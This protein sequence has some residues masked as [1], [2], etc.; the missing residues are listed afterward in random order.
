MS[1]II[2]R[3]YQEKDIRDCVK[4]IQ[5]FLTE[6]RGEESYTNH[7]KNFHFDVKKTE[8]MLK[9]GLY[10][11]KFFCHLIIKDEEIVGGLCANIGELSCFSD[12]VA[13]DELL[14]IVPEFKNLKALFKL[15]EE[16]CFWAQECGAIEARLCSSTGFN[17]EGFTKLCNK[18]NFHQFEI[19]FAR[20]F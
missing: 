20:R 10:N 16:Y 1:K 15:I 9:R 12:A 11:S 6:D 18:L 7:Y 2:L 13:Y 4:K 3:R 5:Q 19:G 17:Q 14:Y 8:R